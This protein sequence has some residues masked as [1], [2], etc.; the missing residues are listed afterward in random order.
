[1]KGLA[2]IDKNIVELRDDIREPECGPYDA[3]VKPYIVAPCTSDIHY[4]ESE[5][6]A[7][8]KGRA[9]GHETAGYVV[10]V[11]SEVKDFKVGDRVVASVRMHNWKVPSV[12]S[13]YSNCM[14]DTGIYSM[15]PLDWQNGTMAEKYGVVDA[16]LNLA[17][18]PENVT[19]EQAVMVT[20]MAA[21]AFEGIRQADIQ[22]G[23]TVVIYGIGAV[24]LMA[25]AAAKIS[26]AGRI[27]AVGSRPISFEIAKEFGATDC[28]SYRDGDVVSQI[29]AANGGQVDRVVVCGGQDSGETIE[30]A[31]KLTKL[32]GKVMNVAVF[33]SEHATPIPYA[34]FAQDIE[35]KNVIARGGRDALD[36]LLKLVQ[37]GRIQ[38]EK[39][40]THRYHGMEFLETALRQMGGND[41]TCIKPV[42]YFDEEE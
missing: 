37:Y 5:M 22:F 29:I 17:H 12:Q 2:L 6:G 1:M 31:L 24:G 15:Q 32:R 20:D 16:D 42:V 28:I 38:P 13:G 21:T 3:V 8:L 41:R 39:L 26:G 19:W 33:M 36:R 34:P 30:A 14:D 27:F 9:L 7:M 25:V 40:V 10:E 23:Q 4:L 35:Y 18:V 11:G